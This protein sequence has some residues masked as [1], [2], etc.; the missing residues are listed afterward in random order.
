MT[1]LAFLG[2]P[3]AAVPPLRALVEA[4]HDVAVVVTRPDRPRGR[5]RATSPSPVKAEAQ[6]LG[7]PVVH[8]LDPVIEAGVD[9][10]VV[11]A[12]GRIVPARVLERVPM[13]NLHFSLLPRWR[14]AA[15]V[16]RAILAGDEV[17]GVSVMALEA[18]LDTGP[19]YARQEVTIG[20][21]DDL[22]SL[23]RR[24]V[25]VGSRMLVEV[26]AGPL[27]EPHP[28]EGAPSYAEK[29]TSEDL[30]LDW[31]RPAVELQRVV[32]L[33]RAWT[34]WRGRRLRILETA[35]DA[36]HPGA[37]AH[38]AQPPGS[39]DGDTVATGAGA[40]RLLRVQPEGKAPME[41]AAWRR[42]ARP[43]PGERLG[44]PSLPARGTS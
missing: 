40:L 25:E 13:V 35:L 42:G 19:V 15:P 11:V 39:I 23:R 10:G 5:G 17:T 12:Y 1:R 2:T 22:V 18:G 41:A 28:Q 16:E 27:P 34:S 24:L 26:L 44:A 21:R 29:I 32:R 6:R 8:G 30:R 36:S 7:L 38:G 20:P 43:E 33:G 37:A 9:L 4:G 3:E 14:G 31:S